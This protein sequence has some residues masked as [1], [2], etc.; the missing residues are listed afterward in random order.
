MMFANGGLGGLFSIF[1]VVIV[2]YIANVALLRPALRTK[3][4]KFSLLLLTALVTA[5]DGFVAGI[6]ISNLV[7]ISNRFG[8][9]LN[10]I[11]TISALIP[12]MV[13]C[14]GLVRLMRLK[15]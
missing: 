15:R 1:W 13:G 3:E 9:L 8:L 5:F 7:G 11:I 2:F 6:A 10:L 14:F 12:F 4:A